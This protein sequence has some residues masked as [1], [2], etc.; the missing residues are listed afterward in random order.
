MSLQHTIEETQQILLA[1][2]LTKVNRKDPI[3]N[4]IRRMIKELASLHAPEVLIQKLKIHPTTLNSI[5][6]RLSCD[7]P[8]LKQEPQ[9]DAPRDV[10][11]FIPFKI[12]PHNSP[13]NTTQKCEFV[14]KNGDRLIVTTANLDNMI[15]V[16]LCCN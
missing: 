4:N 11:N 15:K 12:V 5:R 13:D 8:P 7:N 14:N 9:K 16:F 10:S 1:W 6:Q 2:R 3:P